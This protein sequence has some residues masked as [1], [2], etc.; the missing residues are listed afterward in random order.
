MVLYCEYKIIYCKNT[1]RVHYNYKGFF[2][3]C[4]AV[5]LV[6]VKE[7]FNEYIVGEIKIFWASFQFYVTQ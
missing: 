7:D 3:Q 5:P 2:C 6:N 4:K 1:H